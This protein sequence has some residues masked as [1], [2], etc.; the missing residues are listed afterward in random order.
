MRLRGARRYAM[1]LI[2]ALCLAAASFLIGCD[3]G[4]GNGRQDADVV[5]DGVDDGGGEVPGDGIEDP[6]AEDVAVEDPVDV[7]TEDVT[8]TVEEEIIITPGEGQPYQCETA[9]GAFLESDNYRLEVF[10]APV[11]PIGSV[12]SPTYQLKLGPGS[13]RTP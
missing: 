12:S 11:R 13:T 4:G 6:A 7:P 9:G 3:G 10:I 8:E 5:V 2:D 1:K